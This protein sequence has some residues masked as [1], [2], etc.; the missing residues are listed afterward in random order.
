MPETSEDNPRSQPN[1]DDAAKQVDELLSS[2]ELAEA[3]ESEHFKRFLDNVPIAI[4]VARILGSEERIVYANVAFENLSG[5]T[6][7]TVEG[8][9]WSVLD[10]YRHD[11]DSNR[12]LGQAVLQGEEFLGTFRREASDTKLTL[13]EAYATVVESENGAERFRLAVLVDITERE[14][15]QQELERASRDKDVLLKELQHRVR[16]SL[17]IITALVRLEA[18]NARQGKTLN[19]DSI[20]SRIQALS[21]L[22]DALSS[23]LKGRE[24]DLGEYLSQIASAAMRSHAKEGILLD[25]KVESCMVS[26]NVAMPAGLVVNELMTNAFKHAFAGR[27]HG[28]I[29]LHCLREGGGCSILVADNGVGLPSGVTWPPKGKISTLIVQSLLE[30]AKTNL[31]VDSKPGHGTMVAF[32]IP[33][34]AP[35]A[36][37]GN[38]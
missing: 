14:L 19:F 20:A 5:Q 7:A 4:V 24:V 37:N 10:A 35:K 34:L 30:N 18:R 1:S 29:T 21:I 28:T 3:L 16:N 33:V 6:L 11:E 9:K 36:L 32:T 23:D 26:V 25:L 27:E 15:L 31:K 22:Y 12:R 8:E 13:V 38:E 2:P 17:Q